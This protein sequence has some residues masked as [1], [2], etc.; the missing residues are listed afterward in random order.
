MRLELA[1]DD[2]AAAAAAWQ[3]S[4]GIDFRGDEGQGMTA[5]VNG[6]ELRLARGGDGPGGLRGLV[7][8][9]D[10]LTA[11]KGKMLAAGIEAAAFQQG[12]LEREIALE[13]RTTFRVQITL[14]E[15]GD[16]S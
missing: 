1:A 7:L 8:E 3:R 10:D 5:N 4:L 16:E 9:V 13:P 12:P 11:T 2:L 15:A 14:R 6:V